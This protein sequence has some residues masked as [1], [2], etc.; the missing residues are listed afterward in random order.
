MI[1]EFINAFVHHY[2]WLWWIVG[3][4]GMFAIVV[5]SD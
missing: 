4:L 2:G 1:T 3:L 5:N